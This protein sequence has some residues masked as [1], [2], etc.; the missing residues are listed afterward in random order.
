MAEIISLKLKVD[1]TN[2]NEKILKYKHQIF[3]A[4]NLFLTH[5]HM[6]TPTRTHVHTHTKADRHAERQTDMH[7]VWLS[8]IQSSKHIEVL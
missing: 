1:H 8:G 3:S 5:T 2:L 4:F 6:H 7:A